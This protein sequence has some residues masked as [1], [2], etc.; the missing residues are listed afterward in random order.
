ME[1]GDVELSGRLQARPILNDDAPAFRRCDEPVAPQLLQ[2]SVYMNR[3][4]AGG[5]AELGLRDRQLVS[6]P[7]HQADGLEAHIDFTK[8]VR[9]PGVSIAAADIDHPLPK[10]GRIDERLAPEHVGDARMRAKERPNR[11][12]SPGASSGGRGCRPGCGRT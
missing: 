10:H 8:D 11:L 2:R 1:V 5:V 12:V 3:R 4:E 9:N 6:L 7:V